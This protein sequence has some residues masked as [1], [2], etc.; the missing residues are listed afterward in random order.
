MNNDKYNLDELVCIECHKRWIAAMPKDTALRL[1][2]IE[3]PNCG[4]V[5]GVISTG[6]KFKLKKLNIK[7]EVPK[8]EN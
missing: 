1:I 3:C 5:G 4:Y 6:Q 8:Y 2:D 7:M